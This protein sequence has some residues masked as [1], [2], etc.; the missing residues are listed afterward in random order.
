MRK[1]ISENRLAEIKDGAAFTR[2]ELEAL[3]KAWWITP[4]GLR[5]SMPDPERIVG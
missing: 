4:D 2:A 5:S 3:A 1:G